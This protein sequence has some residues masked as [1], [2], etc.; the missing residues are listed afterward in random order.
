MKI[1]VAFLFQ[2]R[3]I[4]QQTSILG[5]FQ[6]V[7]SFLVETKFLSSD[8]YFASGTNNRNVGIWSAKLYHPVGKDADDVQF[9]SLWRVSSSSIQDL[10]SECK[11]A[12]G[13]LQLNTDVSFNRLFL[14]DSHYLSRFDLIFHIPLK[15][16]A[17]MET[18]GN[19]SEIISMGEREDMTV[20]QYVSHRS[21]SVIRRALGNR[22]KAI[23]TCVRYSIDK[24]SVGALASFVS[25]WE[26][27]SLPKNPSD[28]CVVTLGLVI[29]SEHAHRRVDK[30]IDPSTEEYTA[31]SDETVSTS[32]FS[33]FWGRKSELRR[34]RDGAI[35]DAVV[36]GEQD[37]G[38]GA[39]SKPKEVTGESV[40]EAIVRYSLGMHLPSYSG[41][42]G[43][44]VTCMGSTLEDALPAANYVRRGMSDSS[45]GLSQTILDS[46]AKLRYSRAVEALDK[47]RSI[48]TS[49]MK[50][51]P[52][53]FE[54]ISGSQS[55][56]RYTSTL[57]P[58]PH[59]LLLSSKEMLREYSGVSLSLVA[60]PIL[61]IGQVEGGGKWPTE[62]E[63]AKKIKTALLLRTGHLLRIQFE[64]SQEHIY[65]LI[66]IFLSLTCFLIII[67]PQISSQPSHDF[68]DI[69]YNGYIFRL[70]IYFSS[71]NSSSSEM[72]CVQFYC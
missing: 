9:N 36:W 53:V 48:L 29:D 6:I 32:E 62:V 52:L 22:V 37:V 30:G 7:L 43:E 71:E 13:L 34:F 59:P 25:S 45:S 3:R 63:A 39:S 33:S 16:A 23:S 68:L 69:F 51:L 18:S 27:H 8:L 38:I 47:L 66:Q 56:L 4:G 17:H 55:S 61:I 21:L 14:D 44:L 15:F 28:F 5:A 50:D 58:V 72:R 70:V 65:F 41:K 1:I 35:V 46:T 19:T 2:S 64:V 67:L 54:S 57:P 24:D 31:G 11:I 60:Q 12:L 40:V 26:R 20:P 49:D 10:Q 42:R